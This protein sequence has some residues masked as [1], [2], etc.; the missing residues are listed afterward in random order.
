MLIHKLLLYLFFSCVVGVF[1]VSIIYEVLGDNN[2]V[3]SENARVDVK[4]IWM[5]LSGCFYFDCIEAYGNAVL[6]LFYI[7]CESACFFCVFCRPTCF[8]LS[9]LVSFVF[10]RKTVVKGSSFALF[11]A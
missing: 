1:F 7:S 9:I 11:E 8:M 5:V 6:L 10:S 4:S 3:A 2:E